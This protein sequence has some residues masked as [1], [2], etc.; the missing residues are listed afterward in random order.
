VKRV[1]FLLEWLPE[2]RVA[3][4]E[5]L[6]RELGG[7]EIELE[8]IY[9]RP[10]GE[11]SGHG[12]A[13]SLAW[14]KAAADRRLRIGG[15]H[16][17]L[18]DWRPTAGAELIVVNE[19]ARLLTNYFL[20]ARGAVAAGPE[21]AFWGHGA[22]LDE[23]NRNFAV[24]RAKRVLYRWP[25]WWFAYTD[26]SRDRVVSTG[27]P[28][29]RV[30]VVDNSTSS[31]GL[32]AAVRIAA[33][34]EAAVRAELGLGDRRV[35]LF[36]GSLRAARGLAFLVGAADR[37]VAQVPDFVLVIAGDGSE[38]EHLEALAKS[39]PHVAMAG[40]TD[41][42]S[43]LGL[44]RAAEIMLLPAHIGLN[45]VDGFAAGKPTVTVDLARHGPEFE[46]VSDGVNGVVLP[47]RS[48]EE[49]YAAAVVELLRDDGRRRSLGEGAA[50]TGRTH[51]EEA[52]V[53][54]FADGIEAA[55]AR[56]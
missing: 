56:R 37:I 43:K 27:F 18:Q 2:Y 32:R 35:G 50:S 24:E 19:G 26:G 54:R 25:S 5:G 14:G 40:R 11:V 55:L 20:L 9:G 33:G 10:G 1:A 51:T 12:D 21:I 42:E 22:N 31:E 8:V 3:F 48:G 38:R 41:G 39:R 16:V 29:D 4:F 45:V 28:A 17:V 13:R 6:R 23:A 53:G 52:M 44:L 34:E 30:T 47:A 46:Y 36:L 15:K 49:A 7:R